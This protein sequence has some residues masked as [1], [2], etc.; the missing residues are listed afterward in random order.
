VNSATST[1]AALL[2]APPLVPRSTALGSLFHYIARADTKNFQPANI[3][4]D[5]L[6]ALEE[7]VRD[8]QQRHRL[9]C[10]RALRE[11]AGWWQQAAEKLQP[12]ICH[13]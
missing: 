2:D 12:S 3:T 10:E 9:I 6:P 13:R 1:P 8:R 11:F 5:L 7:K 4:F